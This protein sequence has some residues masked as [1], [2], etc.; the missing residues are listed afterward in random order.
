MLIGF[1]EVKEGKKSNVTF[2]SI[3]GWSNGN[4][5]REKNSRLVWWQRREREGES[6]KSSFVISLK[7]A[8]AILEPARTWWFRGGE[9]NEGG[10][11]GAR[12][13]G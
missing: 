2:H 9:T 10:S 11:G 8:V 3:H 12:G 6:T 13:G 1:K 5:M 4:G 7:K